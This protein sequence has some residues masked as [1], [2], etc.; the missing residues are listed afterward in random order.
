[1]AANDEVI[2]IT[3]LPQFFQLLGAFDPMMS[4]EPAHA[5]VF[6]VEPLPDGSSEIAVTVEAIEVMDRS[7]FIYAFGGIVHGRR[8]VG[9]ICYQNQTGVL[10]FQDDYM[11]GWITPREHREFA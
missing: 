10:T 1:M 5:V 3:K 9:R 4:H 7:F 11:P 8:V 2:K 6:G